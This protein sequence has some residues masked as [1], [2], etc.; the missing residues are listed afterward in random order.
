MA[1]AIFP[2]NTVLVNFAAIQ[3]LDL[4]ES[5]L[6]GRGRWT[7]AVADEAKKS[8]GYWPALC[9]LHDAGWLQEPIEIEG[10]DAAAAV[11]RLRRRVFGGSASE[12]KKHLGESQTCYLIGS[13]ENWHGSWWVSDD[14]DSI[15][16]ARR[17]GFIVL[18]TIDVFRHMV[19]DGD[20]TAGVAFSLMMEIGALRDGLKL[21]GGASDLG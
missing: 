6:R 16:F 17:C 10:D 13:V 18:E 4:L 11:E 15:E 5:W 7:R 20:L 3:R 19:A 21:P 8:S 9:E 1:A 2:D 12:P 14:Q